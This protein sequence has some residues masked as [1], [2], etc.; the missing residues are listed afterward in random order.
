[1]AVITFAADS[2]TLVLNGYAFNSFVSGDILELA[3]V[4]D[5]TSHVNSSAGGVNIQKRS[6][7]DV[8]DLTIRVQRYSDDDTFLNSEMN[9]EQPTLFSGSLKENF[10]KDG[11]DGVESWLMENGSLTTRPTATKNDQDG[12]ALMEYV[13]RFRSAS[14]SL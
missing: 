5:L 6:D 14:R 13:I 11:A 3:P 8:H 10:V 4:N 12:N 1:M 9:Q 7:G 2:T